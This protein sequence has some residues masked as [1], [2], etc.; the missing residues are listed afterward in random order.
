MKELNARKANMSDMA[1]KPEEFTTLMTRVDEGILSNL[2]GK[3]VLTFMIDTQESV[4]TIIKEKGLAQV[5]DDSTLETLVRELIDEHQNIADQIRNGKDSAIGFL[6]GQAMKKT[7][8]KA[9]PKRIGE[10][11]RKALT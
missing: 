7:R 10:L 6:V 11:I 4:D 1:L 3:D 2:V 8:G 9:N 5:S